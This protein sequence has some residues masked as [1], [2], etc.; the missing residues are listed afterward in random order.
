M[1]ATFP[2]END[3]KVAIPLA[4]PEQDFPRARGPAV[5]ERGQRR[6]LRLAEPRMRSLQIRGLLNAFGD[7]GP[8]RWR[9]L[10]HAAHIPR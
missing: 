4:L 9:T 5:P 8:P 7:H 1:T 2:G 3:E 10:A 6:D